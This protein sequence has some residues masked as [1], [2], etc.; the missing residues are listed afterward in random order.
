VKDHIPSTPLERLLLVKLNQN[1]GIKKV[2]KEGF[3]N[4]SGLDSLQ[5]TV[6]TMYT[7][8]ADTQ[9]WKEV[10]VV[11]FCTSVVGLVLTFEHTSQ[12]LVLG[13]YT[14]LALILAW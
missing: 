4:P 11:V 6:F 2:S 14:N 8:F 12:I 10:G 7:L 1:L 13:F 3:P 5:N 9:S